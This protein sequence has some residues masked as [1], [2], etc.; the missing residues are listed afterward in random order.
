VA[1]RSLNLVFNPCSVENTQAVLLSFKKKGL[2][3][4]GTLFQ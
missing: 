4:F 2:N 3:I 1:N